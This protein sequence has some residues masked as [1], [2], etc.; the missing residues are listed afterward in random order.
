MFATFIKLKVKDCDSITT[1]LVSNASLYNYLKRKC[2]YKYSFYKEAVAN[3]ILNDEPITIPDKIKAVKVLIPLNESSFADVLYKEKGL[4]A[5]LDFYVTPNN[6][7]KIEAKDFFSG[8]GILFQNNY[9]IRLNDVEGGLA[10]RK[11]KC[12]K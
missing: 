8:V 2:K 11:I 1:I 12:D 5:I 3:A 9:L 10:V 4:D 7:M 6:T